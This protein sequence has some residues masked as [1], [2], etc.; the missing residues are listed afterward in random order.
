M[1]D[2]ISPGGAGRNRVLSKKDFVKIEVKV[3]S[4]E[5]QTAIAQVLQ[6]ADKEIAMLKQKAEQLRGMKKGAM[7]MLLTG[8]KRLII[9]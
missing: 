3:P 7:Q 4:I 8:K 9:H 2:L 5:E 1:M 6:T